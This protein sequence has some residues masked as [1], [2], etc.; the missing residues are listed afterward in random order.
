MISTQQLQT[1]FPKASPELQ[2]AMAAQIG[3]LF[4]EFGISAK[5]IRA[6]FF[7]AQVG[8][9]SGGGV[10]H[11]ENLNYSA[12]RLCQVWPKH[13]PNIAAANTCAGNP[14]KLANTC[15]ANRM[16]NGPPESGDGW[17]FRGRGLIQITGRDTYT[18]VGQIAGL[19]LVNHPE[20][21]SDPQNALRVACAFWKWKDL[22]SL[23]DTGNFTEVTKRINGGLIGL[24]ERQ[25]WLG[26]VRHVLAAGTAAASP[27]VQTA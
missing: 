20:L 6:E 18:H 21:A 26:K 24:A 19:D 25:A 11:E 12:A 23:S 5:P 3:P 10:V 15:Y 17:R 8:H 1:L 7:L 22:N 2:S 13:F 14:E 27:G 16:G 4:D 9:E